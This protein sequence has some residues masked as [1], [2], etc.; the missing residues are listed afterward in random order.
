MR[1]EEEKTDLRNYLLRRSSLNSEESYSSNM[2]SAQDEEEYLSTAANL[3]DACS[4][5]ATLP[6]NLTVHVKAGSNYD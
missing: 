4:E 6:K 2:T 1:P 3:R 5:F